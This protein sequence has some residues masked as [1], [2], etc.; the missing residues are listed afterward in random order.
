TL[1]VVSYVLTDDAIGDALVAARERNVQ[2]RVIIDADGSTST[3]SELRKLCAAGVWVKVEDWPSK[4]HGKW[5]VADARAVVFGSQNWT[6]AGNNRN[7]ENTLFIENDDFA[8]EFEHEFAR[9][10]ADLAAVE[11]CASL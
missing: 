3:G 2:V 10:W 7:D 5:A 1:D 11:P 9:Q 4:Q 6:A 8:A